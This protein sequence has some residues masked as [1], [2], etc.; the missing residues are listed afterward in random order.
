M[1]KTRREPFGRLPDGE[2]SALCTLCAE[3]GLCVS[4]TNYGGTITSIL[5]PDRE[6]ALGDVVLGYDTLDGYLTG[7][8][9][10]GASIGRF[11][12]RI[13]RGKFTLDGTEYILNVNDGQ[14]HLHGGP[15]GFDR[16]LWRIAAE[17]NDDS[18]LTLTHLSRD[19]E[20]GYP[21]NLQVEV[22]Y[23]LPTSDTLQI[24]YR[25]ET[26]KP[27]P[28]NLTNH[29]YFN[30]AGHTSGRYPGSRTH[31]LR[32]VR[33]A[34]RWRAHPDGRTASGCGHGLRFSSSAPDPRRCRC[35]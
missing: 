1:N 31:V 34:S 20:E 23:S 9:Y 17:G 12:N 30:L 35:Q 15:G 2:E 27:T 11:G 26:D 13:N 18:G 33:Y 3:N 24:Q 16:I 32:G 22:R 7:R 25:A 21:G 5:A 4:I 28:L 14:H 6:G 19:G 8:S 29:S 10:F